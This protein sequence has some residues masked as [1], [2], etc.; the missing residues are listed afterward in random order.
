MKKMKQLLAALVAGLVLGVSAGEITQ[1]GAVVTDVNGSAC[2]MWTNTAAPGTITVPAGGVEFDVLAV[3]GGG[4]GGFCRGG[5][6]GA[7]GVVY[8]GGV[9]FPEGTYTI[10][11]GA[12][13]VPDT[14]AVIGECHKQAPS[15]T[16][17][18][19]GATIISNA[20]E[21]LYTAFGGGG[22]GSFISTNQSLSVARAGASS[23]G[24]ANKQTAVVAYIE[25]QGNKGGAARTDWDGESGGGG[26]AGAAGTPG[27]NTGGGNGGIGFLCTIT[28]DEVYYG[29]G[30]GGGSYL[31]AYGQGGSGGGGDGGDSGR[32]PLAGTDGLGGGGGGSSSYFNMWAH[33]G[34]ARGG[35]GAVILCVSS[36][37]LPDAQ[38]FAMTRSGVT[39]A[40]FT[41]ALNQL[42]RDAT[43]ETNATKCLIY[44]SLGTDTNNLTETCVEDNWTLDNANWS[45]TTNGLAEYTR[46]Y[47]VIRVVNDLGVAMPR[48][49]SGSFDTS[50]TATALPLLA[51]FSDLTKYHG[52]ASDYTFVGDPLLLIDGTTSTYMN[53]S[54]GGE[55]PVT[56]DAGEPKQVVAIRFYIPRHISAA[57]L[58]TTVGGMYVQASNDKQNWTRIFSITNVHP[59]LAAGVWLEGFADHG[60]KWRYFELRGVRNGNLSEIQLM[61]R[62]MALSLKRPTVWTSNTVVDSPDDPD[63]VTITGTLTRSPSDTTEIYGYIA[64][65][66]CG[67]SESNWAAGGTRFTIPG[68]FAPGANY[69]TKVSVSGSGIRYCR[70][71]AKAGQTTA[72][73]ARTGKFA[74]RTRSFIPPLYMT[75][76]SHEFGRLYDGN[77]NNY[78]DVSGSF[79]HIFD[80]TKTPPDQLVTSLRF[81]PRTDNL[82]VW[83]RLRKGVISVSYDTVDFSAVT[84]SATLVP[85]R[86][87]YL[88]KSIPAMNWTV[89]NYKI[90]DMDEIYAKLSEVF[91]NLSGKGGYRPNYLRISNTDYA[92][93]IK[94]V[95][96][97]TLPS[98]GFHFLV[99]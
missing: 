19:G 69:T 64:R 54:S 87:M 75:G 3:G 53:Y 40:N 22:G 71:F 25:G 29:G 34:G 70:V 44:L 82:I 1:S 39:E 60:A 10:T 11:I 58:G 63:G 74:V 4:A 68:T 93:N 83:M 50:G 92:G 21:A 59:P 78:P 47:W 13:G 15:S 46:F 52:G 26:G 72:G 91:L 28:G 2:Y 84:N 95:E 81:W 88:I 65:T 97:R 61:S 99:R 80:L 38:N 27:T 8:A 16:A 43:G 85:G 67:E 32:K 35:S 41:G 37:N 20:T 23:G 14:F 98:H 51:D 76:S 56:F 94:E 18:C 90:D 77:V 42:G 7:G 86:E 62:D 24:N 73:S 9:Q 55:I 30:G 36:A 48:T 17:T 57:A 31:L 6:G 96:L 33:C 89:L 49:F 66:D 12:G 45:F 79:T 5:G